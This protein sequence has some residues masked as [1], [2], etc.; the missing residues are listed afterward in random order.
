MTKWIIIPDVHGR[1]FWRTAVKGQEGEKIIFLGDYVDPYDWEGIL[2]GEA[3]KELKDIIE[4]KKEHPDEWE[5][6]QFINKNKF[7]YYGHD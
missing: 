3:F 1:P 7:H 4:F 5:R 2:P 6:Q